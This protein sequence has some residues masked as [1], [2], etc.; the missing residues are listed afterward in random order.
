MAERTNAQ[1]YAGQ[2]ERETVGQTS[3]AKGEGSTVRRPAG[4]LRPLRRRAADNGGATVM[5]VKSSVQRQNT[6]A[7]AAAT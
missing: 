6:A 1:I 4:N 2:T 7:V 3:E 5:P